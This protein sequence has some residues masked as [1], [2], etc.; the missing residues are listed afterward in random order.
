MCR[1]THGGGELDDN[2]NYS[3]QALREHDVD[4]E[5]LCL[6]G[7]KW[8]ILHWKM[9]QEEKGA[10]HIISIALNKRNEA[11]MKTGHLEIMFTLISLCN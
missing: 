8:E 1:R 9:D 11:A 6:A 2:G 5:R 7:I 3:M 4:W 10:A